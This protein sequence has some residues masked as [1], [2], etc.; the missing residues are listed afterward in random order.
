MPRNAAAVNQF[1]QRVIK[2]IRCAQLLEIPILVTE[3][4]P[5]KLGGTNDQVAGVL[6]D[7]PRYGKMEFGCLENADVHEAVKQQ[8]RK[9]LLIVGME[10]HICIMQT[11]LRAL[12]E[13]YE[14]YV[15]ADCIMSRDAEECRAGLARMD[16]AGATLVTSEM[17][18]FEVLKGAGTDDFRRL[19]PLLKG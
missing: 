6:G 1:L 19:L 14:T 12:E 7:A 9:Q 11:V 13:G 8:G 16:K 17:A 4:N 10:G 15:V 5:G 18:I 2:L 3:Q